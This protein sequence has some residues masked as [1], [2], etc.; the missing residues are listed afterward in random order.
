MNNRRTFV[1]HAASLLAGLGLASA[2]E[3]ARARK[4]AHQT[5]HKPTSVSVDLPNN[6]LVLFDN[7]HVGMHRRKNG[8]YSW[9]NKFDHARLAGFDGF[10]LVMVDT[11]SD[12]WKE[13]HEL[14]VEAPFKVWGFHW[15]TKAVIDENADRIE[16]EIEKIIANV[17]ACGKSPLQPY[18]SLSLSGTSE[19][20][21]PT[22]HER[23]SAKA[24]ERHWQRAYKI[25][26]AFDRACRDNGVTGAL[27]PHINWICDTPQSAE[28]ILE[29]AGAT[30]VGPAFCSHHWYAN[31]NSADLDEVMELPH[32]KD[33]LTYAV[34]TNGMFTDASFKAV[35]FDEGQIDMAWVLASL[36]QKAY[37]GPISTQ[38][39]QIGG[40]PFEACKRF[41]DTVNALRTRFVNH[42]EL[43]PLA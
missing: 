36:Y 26:A 29:G 20:G 10:E 1:K 14:A 22:F 12:A 40:D 8:H 23:G 4:T 3:V 11:A 28:K 7:F 43:N 24:E 41:V 27:Y 31:Q 15:T 6:P 39:W 16:E 17:E 37:Q 34:L 13:V 38:G 30:T 32:H 35:R 21:G 19:L 33:R 25:I 2:P 42:P 9:K 5:S 18:Y